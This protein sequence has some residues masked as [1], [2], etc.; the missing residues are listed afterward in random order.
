V[1]EYQQKKTREAACIQAPAHT[2]P[3]FIARFLFIFF[4]SFFP[5]F[6]PLQQMRDA[7]GKAQC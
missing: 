1:R 5:S 2:P 7:Q 3:R 4:L 6:S